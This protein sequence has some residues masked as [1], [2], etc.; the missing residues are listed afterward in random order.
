MGH[1]CGVTEA[2]CSS[3]VPEVEG[4]CVDDDVTGQGEGLCG[5]QDS[6]RQIQG[7]ENHSDMMTV[8]GEEE[9]AKVKRS[10]VC[11]GGGAIPVIHSASGEVC[12]EDSDDGRRRVSQNGI[13]DDIQ[14]VNQ[15][16]Q[17]NTHTHAQVVW[18]NLNGV[19]GK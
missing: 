2:H 15:L 5:E 12:V 3:A 11:W 7:S 1:K 17:T 8:N 4:G 6:Q 16:R 13:V 18:H 10:H 9:E 14:E 19:T